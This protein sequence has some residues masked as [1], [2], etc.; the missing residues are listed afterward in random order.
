MILCGDAL[1]V[2]R[3]LPG[4]YFNCWRIMAGK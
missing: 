4:D 2:L 1:G 3:E